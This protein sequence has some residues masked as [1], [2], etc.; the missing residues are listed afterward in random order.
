MI[1]LYFLGIAI[2]IVAALVL[3]RTLY[4]GEPVPFVMELPNYRIPT[5]SS[6]LHLIWDKAKDF[7]QRAFSVIFI[8][9]IVV[10]FC[11]HSISISR[12]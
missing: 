3:K 6:V 7:L 2:A 11:N 12:S 9:T 4:S 10:W 1:S 5:V 8:A